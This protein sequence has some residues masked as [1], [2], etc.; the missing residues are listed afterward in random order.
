MCT[1][2]LRNVTIVQGKWIQTLGLVN[3]I[4]TD[5]ELFIFLPKA[6]IKDKT[7]GLEHCF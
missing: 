4:L 5:D 3:S 7:L 1:S 2:D 6:L